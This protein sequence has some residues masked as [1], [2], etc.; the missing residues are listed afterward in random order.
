MS[1]SDFEKSAQQAAVEAVEKRWQRKNDVERRQRRRKMLGN[2]FAFVVLLAG[3]VGIGYFALRHF[4]IDLPVPTIVDI[5][6]LVTGLERGPS[7]AEVDRRGEYVRLLE[8]FRGRTCVQWRDAPAAVKPK[9]A[10]AGVRYL[11]L[12]GEQNDRRLYEL[13]A[14][15]RGSM[16]VTALSPFAAP[17]ALNMKDFRSETGGKPYLVLCND[18]LYAVGCKDESAMRTLTSRLNVR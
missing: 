6:G 4:G 12:C 14:D 18:V 1:R 13:V 15:G 17:I 9:T 16:S 8:S 7:A 5:R 11:A 10:A 3:L 2:L